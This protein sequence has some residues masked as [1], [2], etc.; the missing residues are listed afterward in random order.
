MKALIAIA[1]AGLLVSCTSEQYQ[2]KRTG[3]VGPDGH[4]IIWDQ[5]AEAQY[6]G[7]SGGQVLEGVAQG[8]GAYARGYAQGA[9]TYQSAN[10]PI[11]DPSEWHSGAIFGPDGT[12]LYNL[13]PHGGTVFG[14]NGTTIITGN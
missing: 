3:V 9:A 7:P 6:A 8:V 11:Y 10:R 5:P 14:P 4:T 1:V 12:S 2:A 13:G